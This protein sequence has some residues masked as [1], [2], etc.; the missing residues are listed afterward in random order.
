MDPKE[1]LLQHNTAL[2]LAACPQSAAQIRMAMDLVRADKVFLR[3]GM[4][5]VESQHGTEAYAQHPTC[6]CAY[7]QWHHGNCKHAYARMLAIRTMQCLNT[8]Y[9]AYDAQEQAEGIL[10]LSPTTEETYFMANGST[11]GQVLP[12]HRLVPILRVLEPKDA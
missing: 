1:A 3:Q 11:V 9:Y 2:A 5:H 12:F 4:W 10:W 8:A 6:A 7:S